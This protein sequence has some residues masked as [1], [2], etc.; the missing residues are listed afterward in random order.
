MPDAPVLLVI[1]DDPR[2]RSLV[3]GELRKRY[4][5]DYQVICVDSAD[6]RLGLLAQLRHDRRLVSI[7]LTGPSMSQATGTELLV[8][9]RL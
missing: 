6:D 7:V 4:G 8:R 5:S 9:L 1:D 2:T 3:T